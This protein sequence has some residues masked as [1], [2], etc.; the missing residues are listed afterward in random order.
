MLVLCA[1]CAKTQEQTRL[2]LKDTIPQ[3]TRTAHQKVVHRTSLA[4]PAIAKSSTSH[5]AHAPIKSRDVGPVRQRQA[6]PYGLNSGQ[7]STNAKRTET[8]VAKTMQTQI[9]AGDTEPTCLMDDTHCKENLAELQRDH[10]H[11]WIR[12]E[13][14]PLD[15]VSGVRLYAFNAERSNLTCQELQIAST[16]GKSTIERLAAAIRSNA[17]TEDARR[18]LQTVQDNAIKIAT[19]LAE[20]MVVKCPQKSPR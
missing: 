3:D 18:K 1:G 19:K 5:A 4:S 15:Y 17:I 16:E 9:Q 20:I 8:P 10:D 6:R 13:P 7:Y 11:T 12:A 14:G 2:S